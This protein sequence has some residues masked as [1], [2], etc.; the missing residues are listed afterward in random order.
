MGGTIFYGLVVAAVIIL[1]WKLPTL[2]RPYRTHLYPLT[3]LIYLLTA[4]FVVASSFLRTFAK[5]ASLAEKYQVPA[6][7]GLV[8]IGLVLYAFFR[9]LEPQRESPP[10][11]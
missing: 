7:I 3:P 2:E 6:V 8:L 9:R 1:R 10:V 5:D 4:I 11:P